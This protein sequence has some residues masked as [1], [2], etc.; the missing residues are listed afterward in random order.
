M[1]K[2]ITPVEVTPALTGWQDVAITAHVGAD[3]GNVRG[4]ILH[5]ANQ[6]GAA[7]AFGVRPKGATTTRTRNMADG[8]QAYQVALVDQNDTFQVNCGSTDLE[9]YLIGYLLADEYNGLVNEVE[10]TPTE[11]GIY[12]TVDISSHVGSDTPIG[13]VLALDNICGSKLPAVYIRAVGSSDDYYWRCG[14]QTNTLAIVKLDASKRF[15]AQVEGSC[16]NIFLLGWITA[17]ANFVTDLTLHGVSQAGQYE[18]IDLSSEVDA[19]AVGVWWFR[20]PGDNFPADPETVKEAGS[21]YD[22]EWLLG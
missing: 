20:D 7:R 10:V 1:P 2:A 9:V 14:A 17:N 15:E 19:D 4:A 11:D 18:T 16:A 6:T 3:S 22:D 21:S 8:W 13:A 12:R 5:V